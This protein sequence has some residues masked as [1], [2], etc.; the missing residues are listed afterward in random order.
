MKNLLAESS[1]S[2]FT[3]IKSKKLSLS[4]IMTININFH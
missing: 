4:D 1:G 2:N 3:M